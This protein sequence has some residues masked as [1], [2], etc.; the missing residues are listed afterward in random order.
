MTKLIATL[1]LFGLALAGFSQEALPTVNV[2]AKGTDVRSVL[3]D[4]FGQAKKNYVL[5]PGIRYVLYLSLTD[6]E[7]EEALQLV[8]K[9]ADLKYELQNGIYFVSAKQAQSKAVKTEAKPAK[10][11]GKLPESVLSRT[12]DTKFDKIE[13]RKLFADISKQSG[14]TIEIDK[15]VPNYKLD[16]YL[17]KTSLRFAL[18]SICDAARLKFTFTDNL[19]ILLTPKKD[20]EDSKVA[21]RQN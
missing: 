11:K 3:H 9:N 4:L 5:E 17:I 14:V 1:A 21:I 10:P 12:V 8:C 2:S 16:A 15:S 13:I 19:S 7:F 6:V 20:G 18:T